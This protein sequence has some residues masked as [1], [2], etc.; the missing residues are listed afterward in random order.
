[1]IEKYVLFHVL[2]PIKI[3]KMI[4]YLVLTHVKFF[5][6][7][8]NFNQNINLKIWICWYLISKITRTISTF[9]INRP[10][11]LSVGETQ[12]IMGIFWL[13]QNDL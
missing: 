5:F 2:I 11:F 8:E 4:F 9:M 13:R 1:M 6:K 12:E 3:M 10:N 7:Y